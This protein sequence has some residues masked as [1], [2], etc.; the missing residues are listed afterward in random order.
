MGALKAMF[1]FFTMIRLDIRQ[2]DMDAMDRRFWMVPVVGALYGLIAAVMMT[3]LTRF[4]FVDP[5]VAAVITFFV[6]FAFNRFLH[7]DGT[8]DVGDGLVV[9]GTKEDH[10]R[11]LKDSRIGAGGMAF[12]LM[13]ILM[14]ITMASSIP[15]LAWMAVL[16]FTAEVLAKV[17]MVSAA[18]F[19]EPG[20]GMAGN[21]V[22]NTSVGSLIIATVLAILLIAAFGVFIHLMGTY[23]DMVALPGSDHCIILLTASVVVSILTG[24]IM[25][26]TAKRNFGMVNGD[27]LGAT[28]EITRA[29]VLLT[30]LIIMSVM[31]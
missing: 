22:R 28:N 31:L 11:A 15:F 26:R 2:E 5:L 29:T 18:A 27:V 16:L 7:I 3:F 17:G 8:I 24:I 30:F 20:T 21:S 10:L 14:T 13:V 9:A 12:A 1:S 6:I 23:T 19:G 4:D 25:S